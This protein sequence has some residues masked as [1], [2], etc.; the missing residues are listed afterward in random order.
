MIT[1]AL[2]LALVLQQARGPQVIL[3]V[4]H[5]RVSPG[6]VVVLTIRVTSD[7]SD[8][9]A[10]ELPRLDGFELESRS[11]RTEVATGT[12][13]GRSTFLELKLRA[14]TPGEWRL[15]PVNARQGVAYAQGDAITITIEGGT[16]P[17]VT[18]SLS[19][20]LA[21]IIARAPP[22][23]GLDKAGIS[24][25]LSDGPISVGE[26]VDVVTLAWFDREVRQ[27]LR[28]A[29]TVEAPQVEGVWSYPQAVPG[30]IAATRQV[31]GRWYDLF[32]LHQ[33]AFPLTP[34]RFTVA[35]AKLT[36]HLP[37]AYQFF[38]Q[39]ERY[40][41]ASEPASFTALPL[42]DAGRP[43]GFAGAVGHGLS[44]TR[45]LTPAGARQGEAV[46]ATVTVAGEGNVALW[47]EPPVR[48]PAGVR[49]YPEAA[50]ERPGLTEGRFGGRKVFR[51]L[52]IPDSSGSLS[53]PS[54]SYAYFDPTA[55]RYATAALDAATL[56]VAPRGERVVAR[57][58][59]PPMRLDLRVPIGRRLHRL[60]PAAAWW[61]FA[62]VPVLV[63]LVPRLPRRRTAAPVDTRSP[64]TL[65]AAE[66]RVQRAMAHLGQ[67]GEDPGRLGE[68]KARLEAARFG[69]G[70]PPRTAELLAEVEAAVAEAGVE[71]GSGEP[72]WRERTGLLLLAGLCLFPSGGRA[73]TTPEQ[74]YDA[75][76]YRAAAAGFLRRAELAPDVTAHWFNAGD[77]AFR[78]GSDALALAAWVRAARL[79]PRDGGVRRALVLLP[80]AD[81]QAGD[82]LWVAP[83]TPEELW[84][85]GL[86][87]WLAGWAG[88]I[89][90][91][92]WRGRWL[93]L[94][95]GGAILVGAAELLAHRYARPLAIVAENQQLRLSP[96]ELAPAVGESPALTTVLLGSQRGGWVEVSTPAGQRG[97]LEQRA[98]VP[99]AAPRLP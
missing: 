46:N 13:G 57:A 82:A 20:R 78:G 1:L 25:A 66:A 41:L 93:V 96:H 38:S 67:R 31:A 19:P 74:L 10:V 79:S 64:E 14:V 89:V 30:G 36:F 47:P 17:A 68:L 33:V 43:P 35:P 39:E 32:V 94:L 60:L 5:D 11:E 63:W 72:R 55:G 90:T 92:G 65:R 54:A 3:G 42:P 98:L 88:L 71:G 7:L 99:L 44:V 58:E 95:A 9:I 53:L 49:V 24:V 86:L 76:A 40:E 27:R 2:G 61:L 97:W 8:P 85:V 87:A 16:P 84:L 15:G 22:P 62:L 59:P 18:A 29:P 12:P 34:G 83:V 4:D 80:P 56:T 91:G 69:P 26:Q 51:Y 37:V 48:W 28:R 21:R 45:T 23:A 50:E 52:V 75:G 73:Q 70:S 77:A 6:D 81:A